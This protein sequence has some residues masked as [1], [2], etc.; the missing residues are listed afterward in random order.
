MISQYRVGVFFLSRLVLVFHTGTFI[1]V[2]GMKLYKIHAAVW[3]Y[4]QTEDNN[5]LI[6]VCQVHANHAGIKNKHGYCQRVKMNSYDMGITF[7][8]YDPWRI[9]RTV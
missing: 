7:M 5:P 6:S 8:H 2:L 9:W 4:W 3:T 1:V